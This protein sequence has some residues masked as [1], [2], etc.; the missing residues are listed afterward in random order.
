MKDCRKIQRELSAYL[1]G[2]L[3]PSLR[4]EVEAHLASCAHCQRELLEMK[5][6]TAGVAALPNLKPAPRFLT[7]VRRKIARDE[8]PEPMNWQDY[9]FRPYW[10]KVP[11]PIGTFGI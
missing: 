2:E 3:T 7:E 4:A 9:V 8:K 5:T 1:D 10:L 11:L 6:L